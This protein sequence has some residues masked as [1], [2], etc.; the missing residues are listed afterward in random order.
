MNFAQIKEK[1][2]TGE[3][4]KKN[5][6]MIILMPVLIIVLIFVVT[7]AF[8]QP[9][10]ASADGILLSAKTTEAAKT[11]GSMLKINWKIPDLIPASLRDPMKACSSSASKQTP[12]NIVIKG[13]LYSTEKPSVLIDNKILHQG[14]KVGSSTIIKINKKEVEFELNGKTWTQSIQK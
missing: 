13:I 12:D 4:G 10:S 2:F 1:L 14:D 3:Q 11:V 8:K 5:K 7:R 9:A 6:K